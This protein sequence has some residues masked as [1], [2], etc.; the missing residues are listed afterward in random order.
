MYAALNALEAAVE[1]LATADV[2]ARSSR[3]Q[4][5]VLRRLEIVASRLPA[6]SHRVICALRETATAAELGEPLT[7]AL[8]NALHITPREAKQRIDDAAELGP[9]RALSGQPMEPWLPATAAAQAAGTIRAGHVRVIR[10]FCAALPGH[11]P[12]AD[13]DRA[14]RDLVGYSRGLRPDE[15][16]KL[17]DRMLVLY[18]PDGDF[19]DA[20]RALKRGVSIGRQRPDGMST[21]KGELTPQARATLEPI[22]A[23]L[24]RP[25]MCNPDDDSP[26]GACVD[27]DPAPGQIRA[28]HRTPR[29]R[30]HDALVAAGR[31]VLS[32]GELGQLNGLPATIIATAGLAELESGA[33]QA[34]TAGGTLIPMADVQ[35]LARH[36]FNYLVIFDRN[37]LPLD[38]WRTRRTA[39]PGQRIVLLAKDRGCTRPGCTAT[40]YQCQVHH[41]VADWKHHGHTNINELTLACQPDNLLIENT[42]WTTSKRP[43]GI[44]EWIPPPH[45]DTGQQRTNDYHHPER[46]LGRDGEG[47]P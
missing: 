26:T 39:S 6:T 29:Q 9:R 4:V 3:E 27:G 13:R 42:D 44:T 19:S 11:V 21:L 24:A 8:A 22:F 38:L 14:E 1:N 15:V 34:L 20:E 33:G 45:L 23:K 32:S 7:G 36:A 31:A 5:Q 30:N 2:S 40:G 12:V 37:G 46:L 10:E 28:D 17:A 35:R 16:K 18:H 43:D 47:P 41:A 25:G